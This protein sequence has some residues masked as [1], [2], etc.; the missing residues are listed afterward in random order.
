MNNIDVFLTIHATSQWNELKKTQGHCDSELS[1]AGRIMSLLMAKRQDLSG[2]KAIY[3]SDLKRSYQ[4][5]EP[6]S[7]RIGISI[8]RSPLLREGN[9]PHYH[10]D[11]E[12]PPLP[13]DG[14][15]ENQEALTKR[16]VSCMNDIGKS[17]DRS[18]VL[19]VAHGGFV[20]C[21]LS[22]QFPTQVSEYKGIRT[23]INHLQYADD[24]WKLLTMN[25]DLHLRE[26]VHGATTLDS[27]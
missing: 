25:D 27:G 20:R 1:E 6:L 7:E 23:A 5:A 24:N 19:I 15:F 2:V 4:T 14:P 9:W 12:Y 26:V 21:F 10:R 11:P 18:P 17:E 3:T 22:H 16:A 8:V 13:F